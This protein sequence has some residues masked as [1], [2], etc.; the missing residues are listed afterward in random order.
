MGTRFDNRHKSDGRFVGDRRGQTI[1]DFAV[2]VSVFAIVVAFV[3]G[4]VPGFLAQFTAGVDAAERAQAD[5]LARALVHNHST[6]AGETTLNGTKLAAT[7]DDSPDQVRDRYGLAA[8]ADLNVTV[9]TI[10]DR[11]VVSHGGDRL[12]L[13]RPRPNRTAG[14]AARVVTLRESPTCSPGCRLVVRVW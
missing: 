13:G 6:P 4:M 1:Q 5:R 9:R 7:L 10:E 11:S 3:F 2:G 14:T 8:T 12:A